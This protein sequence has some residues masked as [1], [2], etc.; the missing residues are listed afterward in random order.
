VIAHK[1]GMDQLCGDVGNAYVNAFTN[2]KVYAV[3]GNEFGESLA[4]CVIIIKKALYGLR[5]SSEQWYA[6]FSDPL[7]GIGFKPT[8]YDK[9]IW[10]QL[11]EAGDCYDYICTHVDDFMIVGTNPQ[12]VMDMI[13][14]IY[15]VKSIGPPDYYL[16]NDYKKD[17]Q[18]RWCVGCKKYLVEAIKRVERMFGNLM[19]YS[20][21]METGPP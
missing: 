18:G 20:H 6:H 16:G 3:T 1:T 9:D 4:E 19:K 10:I 17:Q 11:N 14:S 13:Q 15:A 7:C 12:S 21:P 5:T 8:R 2:E